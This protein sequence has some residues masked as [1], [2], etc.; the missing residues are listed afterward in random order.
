MPVITTVAAKEDFIVQMNGDY[1]APFDELEM[2]D[3]VVSGQVIAVG[4]GFGIAAEVGFAGDFIRVMVRGNPTT[5]NAQALV[6]Y[7]P[8]THDA[9]FAEVGIVVVNK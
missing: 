1:N 4:D 9:A 3:Y 6:G 5:V 7:V 2:T 8:A